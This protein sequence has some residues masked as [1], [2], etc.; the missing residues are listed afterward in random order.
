MKNCPSLMMLWDLGVLSIPLR[1]LKEKLILYHH[2]ASLPATSLANQV[3]LSQEQ[4]HF[5]SLRNEVK[6]FLEEFQILDVTSY[7]KSQWKCFV[8]AKIKIL[9]QR[10]LLNGMKQYKKV[11]NLSLSL[12]EFGIKDYFK[13]MSLN[14]SRTWFRHR[15]RTMTSCRIDYRNDKDNISNAFRCIECKSKGKFF[16][17]QISHWSV[18]DSYSFLK[19]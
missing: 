17:D 12:E 4:H 6:I 2:I 8:D 9:N 15:A 16:I 5:P 1:L 13:T 3:M 14:S 7:S 19:T 10:Y 18:C 11:D